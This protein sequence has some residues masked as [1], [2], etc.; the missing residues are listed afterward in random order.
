MNIFKTQ[1]LYNMLK[2]S[3]TSGE[4][5]DEKAIKKKKKYWISYCI[6]KQKLCSFPESVKLILIWIKDQRIENRENNL[7]Q[8]VFI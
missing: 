2:K 8:T 4:K 6:I 1:A 5:N 3:S 7:H